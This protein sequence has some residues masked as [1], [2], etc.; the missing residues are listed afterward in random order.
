MP[1]R[2]S[3]MARLFTAASWYRKSVRLKITGYCC[4]WYGLTLYYNGVGASALLFQNAT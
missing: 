4:F 2:D 3:V 1:S